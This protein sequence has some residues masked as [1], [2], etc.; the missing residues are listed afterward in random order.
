MFCTSDDDFERQ[1]STAL[2][3]CRSGSEKCGFLAECVK[4][5]RR[6]CLHIQF[7]IRCSGP[8]DVDAMAPAKRHRFWATSAI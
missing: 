3:R 6:R 7:C 1:L 8:V 5:G 4:S 2:L